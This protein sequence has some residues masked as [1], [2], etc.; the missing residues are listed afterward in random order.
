MP[1]GIY[2]Y[3]IAT[4]L[5][6]A[7][8]FFVDFERN[9]ATRLYYDNNTASRQRSLYLFMFFWNSQSNFE[10]DSLT[11][12]VENIMCHFRDSTFCYKPKWTPKE[13]GK[14]KKESCVYK[15]HKIFFLLNCIQVI[16]TALQ[17]KFNNVVLS[18]LKVRFWAMGAGSLWR[19]RTHP[20]GWRLTQPAQLRQCATLVTTLINVFTYASTRFTVDTST[21]L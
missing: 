5:L 12:E 4:Y 6:Q 14:S 19:V 10:R 21:Y 9:D 1:A 20:E 2:E 17:M 11:P 7:Y 16:F 3:L 13:M 15:R 8:P 18:I